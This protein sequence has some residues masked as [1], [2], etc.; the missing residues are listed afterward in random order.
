[1]ANLCAS[2]SFLLPVSTKALQIFSNSPISLYS[3]SFSYPPYEAYFQSR[4]PGSAQAQRVSAV[5]VMHT[6]HCSK[7]VPSLFS[8]L[9]LCSISE[10]RQS[11]HFGNFK[12]TVDVLGNWKW[13]GESPNVAAS[14]TPDLFS[15][16]TL[17][18]PSNREVLRGSRPNWVMLL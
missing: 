16:R 5:Q 8:I 9:P 4:E 10:H 2:T 15:S 1:M 14:C 11:A 6:V 12:Y 17:L 18:S 13:H 3:G 7:Y